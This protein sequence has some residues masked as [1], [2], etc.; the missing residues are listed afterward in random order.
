VGYKY[1]SVDQKEPTFEAKGI[2]TVRRDTCPAVSKILEKSLRY[3]CVLALRVA[4]A[5]LRVACVC[6]VACAVVMKSFVVI[7]RLLFE[8][9]DISTIKAFVQRQ[10]TKLAAGRVSLKDF[11]FAKEVKLGTYSTKVPAPP[12]ALVCQKEMAG[13]PRA[14]P[15]Y[16]ERVPYVVVCGGPQARLMDLVVSPQALI[17]NPYTLSLAPLNRT[18]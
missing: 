14:E 11:I 4:C 6:D 10:W 12:A 18:H 1:E 3:L 2:E 8:Q 16:G 9:G 15:R 7:C 5:V 13:D 17:T